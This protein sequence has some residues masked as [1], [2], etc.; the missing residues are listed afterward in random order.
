MLTFIPYQG[1]VAY[2]RSY[3]CMLYVNLDVKYAL[4]LR[5]TV[6]SQHTKNVQYIFL[7]GFDTMAAHQHI[8]SYESM[9]QSSSTLQSIIKRESMVQ[10]SAANSRL[11]DLRIFGLLFFEQSKKNIFRNKH[12]CKICTVCKY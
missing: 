6:F 9:Y 7:H 1:Q 11:S 5:T 12:T 10:K 2:Y 8:D 4:L 3:V